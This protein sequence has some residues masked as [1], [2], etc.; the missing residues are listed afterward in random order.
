MYGSFLLLNFTLNTNKVD[1][2]A[3]K[4]IDITKREAFWI[5]VPE[6]SYRFFLKEKDEHLL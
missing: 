5:P 3:F 6:F 4:L 2:N 1:M